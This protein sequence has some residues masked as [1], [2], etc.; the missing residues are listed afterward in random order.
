MKHPEALDIAAN[1]I[2]A[3]QLGWIHYH[4]GAI[5]SYLPETEPPF[6]AIINDQSYGPLAWRASALPMWNATDNKDIVLDFDGPPPYKGH[7]WLPLRQNDTN[8]S[9]TPISRSTY[10]IF[11]PNWGSWAVGAQTHY[12]FLQN[13]ERNQ[14][15]KFHFGSDVDGD[16][17]EAIWN[18]GYERMNIN[19]LAIWGDDIID[20]APFM[21]EEPPDDEQYL[22]ITLPRKLNRRTY[23]PIAREKRE[24]I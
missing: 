7:R 8:I 23:T 5:H 2:N 15:N 22:S 14:L 21:S 1:L 10:E 17:R 20:N 4:L 24:Y 6:S 12:S 18:M 16:G 11:S 19:L 9:K 3:A 13:L